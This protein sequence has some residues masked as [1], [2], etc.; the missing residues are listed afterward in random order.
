MD[1]QFFY[2][3]KAGAFSSAIMASALQS[4]CVLRVHHPY[5]SISVD[6]W[7]TF[8]HIVWKA[9][10]VCSR[11]SRGQ[12]ISKRLPV[13]INFKGQAYYTCVWY[14]AESGGLRYVSLD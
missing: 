10:A 2:G 13:T 7:S 5:V 9:C 8:L 12:L 4:G 3:A 6:E 14:D 11:D 1:I